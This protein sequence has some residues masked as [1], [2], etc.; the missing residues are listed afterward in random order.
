MIQRLEI[1]GV[2]LELSD[3]MRRY[4]QRKIGRL[5]RFLPRRV[6]ASI[7]AEVKLKQ[8]KAKNKQE[9]TCEVIMH[10]PQETFTV[11]ETT[12][13]IFAAIDIAEEK[14]KSHITKYKGKHTDSKVRR[15]LMNRLGNGRS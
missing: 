14:L 10:L 12:I 1:D 3:D 4:V 9:R 6:R 5:D 15:R 11:K 7:H 2:H 8:S 13:N